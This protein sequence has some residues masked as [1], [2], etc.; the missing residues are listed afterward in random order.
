MPGTKGG[1]E[2]ATGARYLK[3]PMGAAGRTLPGNN[4]RVKGPSAPL[5]CLP[6]DSGS[7]GNQK[8][9]GPS[10]V[11]RH[12]RVGGENTIRG[13]AREFIHGTQKEKLVQVT[14]LEAQALSLERQA[15]ARPTLTLIDALR[16]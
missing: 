6:V 5:N 12:L 9:G 15:K 1:K 16:W 8:R 13:L 11:G 4:D 10:R 14:A 2:P 3:A 7:A